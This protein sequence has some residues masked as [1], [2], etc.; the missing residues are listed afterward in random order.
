MNGLRQQII[1]NYR[2]TN[3]NNAKIVSYKDPESHL[4]HYTFKELNKASRDWFPLAAYHNNEGELTF[5][6]NENITHTYVQGETGSGKTTRLLMQN[7]LA[8]SSSESKPSLLIVDPYGEI[9][10]NTYLHFKKLKY[11]TKVLNC[12]NPDRSDTYNP[13]DRITED[14]LEKGKISDSATKQIDKI[15]NVM[16]PITSN[17]DMTWELGA[18]SYFSGVILDLYEDLINEKIK[19]EFINLYNIIERHFWVRSQ[20]VSMCTNCL[21]NLSHYREKPDA[22]SIKRMIAVTNNAEKTR[23]SYW[24]VLGNHIDKYNEINMYMLSSN[25]TI[26][27]KEFINEPTVIFIQTGTSEIGDELVSMLVNDIYNQVTKEGRKKINKR[28]DR[29][30]HCFLDEF[31]NCNFGS[32]KE[33][34]KMLTTSRKFGMKWHMYLQCDAQL[35]YKYE[36]D[37]M[38]EII[39]SNATEIFIGSQDYKTLERFA[40]SCGTRTIED[41]NSQLIGNNIGFQTV[42]LL[43]PDKLSLMSFG[44]IYVKLNREHLLY[45]Y[46]DPFYIC[47]EFEHIDNIELIYPYNSFDY[48]E[49]KSLPPEKPHHFLFDDDDDEPKPKLEDMLVWVKTDNG[50]MLLVCNFEQYYDI[51]RYNPKKTLL[52]EDEIKNAKDLISIEMKNVIEK[53]NQ[54]KILKKHIDK[55]DKI[56]YMEELNKLTL[57][58]QIIYEQLEDFSTDKLTE[59]ILKFTIIEAFIKNN[60]YNKIDDWHKNFT[61]EYQI[62]ED[63]KYFPDFLLKHFNEADTMFKTFSLKDIKEIKKIIEG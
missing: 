23:D 11:N 49:T 16:V 31:A 53:A 47:K 36:S 2:N 21:T 5:A 13:F 3:Y 32:G 46:Y 10:E 35:D 26:D 14:V 50:K 57:I 15:C 51:A 55:F 9:Y 61:K 54:H 38:G 44:Y 34:T 8:L 4:I 42:P 1:D 29:D 52:Y 7:V 25:S 20:I 22:M 40:S 60:K 33:F 45:S 56:N 6:G 48:T 17:K 24:G 27:I 12:D 43:T 41:L 28:L 37:Q 39:R 30:I 62:L 59:T 63:K 58:P 19:P 18:R